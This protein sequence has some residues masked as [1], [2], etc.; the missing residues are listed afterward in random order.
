MRVRNRKWFIFHGV[1]SGT[2]D[3]VGLIALLGAVQALDEADYTS[4][5]WAVLDNAYQNG[6]TVA[7]DSNATQQAV[8]DAASAIQN[9][10]DALVPAIENPILLADGSYIDLGS[11][12]YLM[13]AGV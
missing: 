13:L 9:A 11:D 6:V 1:A 2:A 7:A 4:E 8:N 10:I 12:T 5:S 3:K